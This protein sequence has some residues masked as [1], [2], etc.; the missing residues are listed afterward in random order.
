VSRRHIVVVASAAAALAVAGSSVAAGAAT[1]PATGAA[2]PHVRTITAR[3]SKQH[4]RLSS[5]HDIKAG[6]VQFTVTAASGQHEL[7]IVRLHHGYSPQ[8]FGSDI[9]KAF[10]G[11]VSA[12]RRVDH[13]VT[14]R[15]GA[16][17]MPGQPG[18]FTVTLAAGHYFLV[19]AEGR[20]ASYL[21]VH[22]TAHR[23]A[24][25][26]HGYITAETY[27]FANS[28]LPASGDIFVNN[29]SDQPHVVEMQHVKDS[30][31]RAQVA[32][33]IKSG[34]HGNPSFALP[35]GT[36]TGI[37]SPYQHEVFRVHVPAGKYVVLCYWPDDETGMPHFMMGMWELV[38]L[39]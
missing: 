27:G 24:V 30:T 21:D 9:N 26:H 29:V 33:F 22:G 23:T 11:T 12:V 4:I 35:E 34:A 25:A 38:T 28:R 10:S 32:R 20:A 37:L 3:M 17:A 31:T 13:N 5:G 16:P 1:G 14:F 36:G 7:Q 6:T 2:G 15:G 19:D 8:Q 18:V 39:H